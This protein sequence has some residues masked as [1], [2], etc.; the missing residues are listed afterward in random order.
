[1]N[2]SVVLST[3]LLVSI[4]SMASIQGYIRLSR[5]QWPVTTEQIRQRKLH[6]NHHLKNDIKMEVQRTF[7]ARLNS[8]HLAKENA[9]PIK[10][11]RLFLF[12]HPSLMANIMPYQEQRYRS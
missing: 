2:S 11:I 4:L 5:R 9:K 7:D 3:R 12:R 8:F 6:P 10:K 1:M